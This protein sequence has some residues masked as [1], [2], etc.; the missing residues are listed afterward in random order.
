MIMTCHSHTEM[1]CF[2]LE[3]RAMRPATYP[4]MQYATRY[5]APVP[6]PCQ[7]AS[8]SFPENSPRTMGAMES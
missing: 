4:P 7:R 5:A 1:P 8:A 6:I 3:N 2:A